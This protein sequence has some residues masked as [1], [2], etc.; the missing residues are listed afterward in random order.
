MRRWAT[1]LRQVAYGSPDTGQ[2]PASSAT[3]RGLHL[4]Y[5]EE[6]RSGRTGDIP[7]ALTS[8]L[9]SSFPFLEKPR[10]EEPPS[11]PEPQ[12]PEETDSPRSP[13]P[14]EESKANVKP[15]RQKMLVRFPFRKRK[16]TAPPRTPDKESTGRFSVS[17]DK[18]DESVVTVS[19]DGSDTEGASASTGRRVPTSSR[20]RKHEGSA[21]NEPPAKSPADREETPT[22]TGAKPEY[23]DDGGHSP[24]SQERAVRQGTI[25]GPK[26]YGLACLD[27]TLP[28]PL[29]RLRLMPRHGSL[30]AR[31]RQRGMRQT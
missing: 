8:S 10:P 2:G 11:P 18:E 30:F 1:A 7:P 14:E 24:K 12:Q 5:S 3:P 15:H 19:D 22:P 13:P 27:W 16:V 26:R 23:G 28:W 29:R 4:D 31:R 20:K 17:S 9:S 6:F 25:G 21:A